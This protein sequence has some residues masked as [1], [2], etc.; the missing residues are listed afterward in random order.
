M[1]ESISS[2]KQRCWSCDTQLDFWIVKHHRPSRS[3]IKRN[4][5]GR[6]TKKRT[7]LS[8]SRFFFHLCQ[9]LTF[10]LY[11]VFLTFIFIIFFSLDVFTWPFAFISL[12]FALSSLF[13]LFVRFSSFLIFFFFV[14]L[15]NVFIRT[16]FFVLL[17]LIYKCFLQF[18]FYF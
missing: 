16:Q 7:K 9:K 5:I 6:K 14:Y 13:F 18:I 17:F 11:F 4:E 3:Q 8:T 1:L 12:Y 15:H 2:Q 10:F